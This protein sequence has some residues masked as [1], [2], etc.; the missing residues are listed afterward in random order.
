MKNYISCFFASAILLAG[1]NTAE[2]SSVQPNFISFQNQEAIFSENLNAILLSFTKDFYYEEGDKLPGTADTA[3]W[4][5]SKP[6]P[7]AVTNKLVQPKNVNGR[8]FIADFGV[9]KTKEEA[10]T[11]YNQQLAV[12]EK[13]TFSCCEMAKEKEK[14]P[15]TEGM[16]FTD[17]NEY[18]TGDF[19]NMAL[20]LLIVTKPNSTFQVLLT[21]RKL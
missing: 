5:V 8:T 2:A 10:T 11:K 17:A 4:R 7:G 20:R 14:T 9:F 21:V 16:L 3:E 6:L 13:M 12:L 19:D 18:G 15:N 1:F